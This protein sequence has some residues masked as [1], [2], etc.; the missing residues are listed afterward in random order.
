[1]TN[2][3]APFG[4]RT[5]RTLGA[6]DTQVNEYAHNSS[7]SNGLYIGDAV[8]T[9]HTST[10]GVAGINDGT[11]YC[12]LVSDNS[13]AGTTADL[14]GAVQ[15]VR[16]TLTNLTLQYC[17]ASVALGIL[18]SDSPWQIYQ[19]MSDG[20]LT[21]GSIGATAKYI[22]NV[23]GASTYSGIS[24]GELHQSTV[25]QSHYTLHIIRMAPIVGNAMGANAIVEVKINQHELLDTS[26]DV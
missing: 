17:P 8:V 11:P 26:G 4:L 6:A 23:A 13:G 25:G 3:I 14:R 20:T 22:N 12:T 24:G 9:N 15:G 18:V 10:S 5:V 16:P 2:P 1:M 19:V 7:D 21:T